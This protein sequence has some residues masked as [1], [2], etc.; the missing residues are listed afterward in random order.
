M[1]IPRSHPRYNSL[2]TR[3]LIVEGIR[4]GITSIDG[5]IAHGR[6]EVFDY[7]LGEKTTKSAMKSIEAAA[8]M[9]LTA[10]HPVVSVNGNTAALVPTD[11]SE[12]AK[13]IPAKLEV[14]IFH[15]SK[16]REVKIKNHLIQNGA[17]EVLLPQKN[18]KINFLES[19][20]RYVNK[21]GIYG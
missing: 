6:G 20:R 2:K 19:N 4:G 8:A 12:L 16:N 9:L 5:L 15:T 17:K 11:I 21:T 3:E 13:I 14:N 18:V 7:L 1:K 10:K